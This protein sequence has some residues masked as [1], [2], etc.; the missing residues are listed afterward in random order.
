MPD[1]TMKTSFPIASVIDAAQRKAQMQQEA[2]QN[3]NAQVLQG[4]TAIGQ[5]GK[6]YFDRKRDMAQALAAGQALGIDPDTARSMGSAENVIKVANVNKGGVD[7]N[8]L[9]NMYNM[10]TG[11]PLPGMP[12]STQLPNG[13]SAPAS[14][15]ATPTDPAAP[16]TPEPAAATP[17]TPA[18]PKMVNKATFDLATKL[19]SANDDENV[20]QNV[21]G[22]GLVKVGTKKKGDQ[23]LGG[24]PGIGATTWADAT[25]QE[26]AM[27]QGLYEGRIRPADVGF[28]E[29]GKM[30]SLANEYASNNGLAPFKAYA[31]EVNANMNKYSTTGKMGQNALSLNTALGHAASAYDAYQHIQNT[32]QKWLNTPL[33]QLRQQTNDPEV[34]KLGITLTALQGELANVFKNS[35]ATDQE[36]AEWRD[37]LNRDL[38]PT[39]AVS[40]IGKVDELLRSRMDALDYQRAQA[41]GGNGQPLI[42]P[43]AQEISNRLQGRNSNGSSTNRSSAS[44]GWSYVGP[45]K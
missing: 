34:V 20:Y 4:L 8:M 45:A 26:K 36:I 37:Y 32:D 41:G 42:S 21:P 38:T 30:V 39:Q 24:A 25:D 16:S 33:N 17:A 28:R 31:G 6:S 9:M 2:A 27:A 3:N 22:K 5:I 35:G 18:M 19:A 12:R 29:R 43:H 1:F 14:A 13:T 10:I 23:V 44:G 40:A 11:K 7:T 15:A